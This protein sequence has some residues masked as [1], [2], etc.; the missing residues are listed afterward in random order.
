VEYQCDE[1][2]APEYDR[3]ILYSDNQ[4][5]INWNIDHP[6][7]SEKDIKLPIIADIDFCNPGE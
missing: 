4:L 6:V 1:Y 5:G 7:L 3:G 2:F